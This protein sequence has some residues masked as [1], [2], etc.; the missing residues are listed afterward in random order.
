MFN[1]EIYQQ[2]LKEFGEENIALVCDIIS[3]LY[4]IKFNSAPHLDS[5]TEFDYERMW[6]LNKYQELINTKEVI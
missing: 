2:L 1:E 4:H 6:W 3:T 5:F